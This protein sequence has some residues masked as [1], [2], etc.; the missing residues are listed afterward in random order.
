MIETQTHWIRNPGQG[1]GGRWRRRCLT[2]P[3]GGSSAHSS[4]RT[5]A[6]RNWWLVWYV[7]IPRWQL[8]PFLD[9][10]ALFGL[11]QMRRWVRHREEKGPSPVLA[12][13]GVQVKREQEKHPQTIGKGSQMLRMCDCLAWLSDCHCWGWEGMGRKEMSLQGPKLDGKRQRWGRALLCVVGEGFVGWAPKQEA[14]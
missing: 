1:R 10:E 4:V 2:S 13:G 5:T 6:H 7:S 12:L 14:G 11:G 9:Q 3:T 8:L